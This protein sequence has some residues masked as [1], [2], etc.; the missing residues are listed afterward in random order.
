MTNKT[1]AYHFHNGKLR[2]GRPV[3]AIGQWLEHCGEIIPC[4]SGLH[5]SLHPFDALTCSPGAIL[6]KVEVEDYIEHGNGKIVGRRRK[7]LQQVD[8]TALLQQFAR[9]CASMVLHLWD[10]PEIVKQYLATGDESIRAAAWAAA[11]DAAW[12]AAWAAARDAAWAAA[13]AAARDAA[14]AAARDAARDAAWAAERDAAW[15]AERAAAWAAARDA[16]WAAERDAAWAAERDA[17]WDAEIQRQ[18][19]RFQQLVDKVFEV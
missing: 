17:A 14:W 3:P 2:D 16:A 18:R 15:A 6:C 9:D 11:R 13:W 4:Q 19:T 8:A 5:A 12:A 7:I 1:I 10:A